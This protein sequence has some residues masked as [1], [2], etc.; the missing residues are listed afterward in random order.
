[1]TA[2]KK[3]LM[4][5]P[6]FL[7]WIVYLCITANE[8]QNYA[9]GKVEGKHC[10]RSEGDLFGN[11]YYFQPGIKPFRTYMNWKEFWKSRGYYNEK[12]VTE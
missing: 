1:M 5:V 7:L 11:T 4:A 10:S 8:R 12:E 3:I 2:K 6:Y 9:M